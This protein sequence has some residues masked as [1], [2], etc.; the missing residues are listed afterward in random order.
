MI[1]TKI[2]KKCLTD[3]IVA[4]V[5]LVLGLYHPCQPALVLTPNPPAPPQTTAF[6][7][8]PV[9]ANGGSQTQVRQ[10]LNMMHRVEQTFTQPGEKAEI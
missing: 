7:G 10:Q 8:I 3:S 2:L 9:C 5:R 4:H 1:K 6:M